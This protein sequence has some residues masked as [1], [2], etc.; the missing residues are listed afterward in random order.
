MPCAYTHLARRQAVTPWQLAL[1]L[2]RVL[3]ET[4]A[5]RVRLVLGL[6]RDR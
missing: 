5:T 3:V 6:G 4:V 2:A 1:A